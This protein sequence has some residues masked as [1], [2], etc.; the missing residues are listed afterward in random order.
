MIDKP[1]FTDKDGNVYSGS[2]KGDKYHGFGVMKYKSGSRY[3]GYWKNGL[4][5]GFGDF[6]WGNG[7]KQ[8]SEWKDSKTF[9]FGW[10]TFQTLNFGVGL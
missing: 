3:V 9:G 2:W 1:S 6:I 4:L 10:N 8:H 7:Q 5:N